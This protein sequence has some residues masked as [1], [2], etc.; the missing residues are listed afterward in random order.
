MQNGRTYDRTLVELKRTYSLGPSLKLSRLPERSHALTRKDQVE[1]IR[2]FSA[3]TRKELS[4]L[5][6]RIMMSVEAVAAARALDDSETI[7]ALRKKVA[8]LESSLAACRANLS[9][10]NSLNS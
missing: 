6:E 9:D 4:G 3:L 1:A 7:A 5:P 10:L 2:A 8:E